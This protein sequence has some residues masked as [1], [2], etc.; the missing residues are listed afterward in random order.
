M[1]ILPVSFQ[2]AF[3][4]VYT[5]RI[6]IT[7]VCSSH[8]C[9]CVADAFEVVVVVVTHTFAINST[10]DIFPRKNLINEISISCH[11]THYCV[12]VLLTAT[13]YY[14]VQPLLYYVSRKWACLYV[15]GLL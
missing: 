9:G 10:R 2:L 8:R 7:L 6:E 12:I 13:K 4:N 1:C 15:C 3:L 14:L 5:E 11:V